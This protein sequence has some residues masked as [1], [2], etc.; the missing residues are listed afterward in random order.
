MMKF[1]RMNAHPPAQAPQKPPR[2]YETQIPT[3]IAS[4]PGSDWH[5]AM[6]SRISSFVSHFFSPTSSRSIWPT[7]GDRAAEAEQAEP[8]EIPHQ[9]ADRYA[10]S[11]ASASIAE[12]SQQVARGAV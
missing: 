4:G 2:M 6:P 9:I 7:R 8:K 11:R 3:C 5:T 12:S 10:A 1:G